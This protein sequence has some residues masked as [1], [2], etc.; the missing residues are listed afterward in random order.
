MKA[1]GK[2]SSQNQFL[3]LVLDEAT[4]SWHL[5][6]EALYDEPKNM[7]AHGKISGQ[8]LTQTNADG[9]F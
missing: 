6:F 7:K 9:H 2:N 1:Y 5:D 8:N 3:F 4:W